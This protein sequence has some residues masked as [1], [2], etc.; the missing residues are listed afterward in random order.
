MTLQETLAELDAR[1]V[2]IQAFLKES[3]DILSGVQKLHSHNAEPSDVDKALQAETDTYVQM[4]A[5]G[6]AVITK[7]EKLKNACAIFIAD[8]Y[9]K[10][11]VLETVKSVIAN[12]KTDIEEQFKALAQLQSPPEAV[13]AKVT[14]SE[15]HKKV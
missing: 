15:P 6:E 7:V 12:L 13:S 5:H 4:I 11:P 2:E 10:Q 3:R 14:F 8:G 1:V 9:P